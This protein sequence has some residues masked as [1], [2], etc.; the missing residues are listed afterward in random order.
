MYSSLDIGTYGLLPGLK[1]IIM[2]SLIALIVI[3]EF[4]R[5][6]NFRKKMMNKIDGH[7]F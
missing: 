1:L 6:N 4:Q 7:N 3:D 2:R 5:K